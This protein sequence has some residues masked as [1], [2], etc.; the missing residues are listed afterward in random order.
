MPVRFSLT[1]SLLALAIAAIACPAHAQTYTWTGGGQST[2]NTFWNAPANWGGTL[3]V[4]SIDT[5][6]AYVSSS[7]NFTSNQNI[8]N[9][10]VLNSLTF[11]Q[12]VAPFSIVGSNGLDFRTSSAGV[13]PTIVLTDGQNI[14]VPVTFTN[15]TAITSP[16]PGVQ[17]SVMFN[18]TVGG[19]GALTV[20]STT[21]TTKSTTVIMNGVVGLTA[22]IT[23]NRGNLFLSGA[24]GA[25]TGVS[26]F[27]VN[28]NGILTLSDNS[29]SNSNR[30]AN[31][32]TV[33]LNGGT[34][35]LTPAET[36]AGS[37]ETVGTIA[38]G[39]G[40]S[41]V[42]A[43]RGSN[44]STTGPSVI[45]ATNAPTRT[46][47]SIV[48]YL[49]FNLGAALNATPIGG[50]S[51]IQYGISP[52]M[53]GGGGADGTTT[54]SILPQAVGKDFSVGSHDFVTH[55]TNGIRV[56]TSAEYSTGLPDGVT[57]DD[58]VR[59]S[60]TVG[61]LNSATT[62]VNALKVSGNAKVNGTGTLTIRSG[63]I[64]VG[65]SGSG[66]PQINVSTL[67]FGGREAMF[68]GQLNTSV[69]VQSV[70]TGTGGLTSNVSLVLGGG[71]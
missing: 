17:G 15:D 12:F 35:R 42:E 55:G 41:T 53:I 13:T 2:G 54:I 23:I 59:V 3:P 37:S 49:G 70:I 63:A 50:V 30:I 26:S 69:L 33:T 44:P 32:A 24:D 25:A 48:D 39:T 20:G 31:T 57:S 18:S 62:A 58:N 51:R 40:L 9:P 4:S 64:L 71:L 1:R 11:G 6:I 16:G 5:T 28:Q 56:L 38:F 45:I 7:V 10:F 66:T 43:L 34:L 36:M 27:A 67:A 19:P 68:M 22:T 61:G 52:T 21:S 60:S 47:G 65:D 14:N 29:G 8:A 46:A